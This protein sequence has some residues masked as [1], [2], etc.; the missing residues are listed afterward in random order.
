M[1]FTGSVQTLRFMFVG[2]PT[3][4]GNATINVDQICAIRQFYDD[5][6]IVT[7]GG[8]FKVLMSYQECIDHIQTTIDKHAAKS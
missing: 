8:V 2:V 3:E 6:Q 5:V 7:T 1:K 4:T